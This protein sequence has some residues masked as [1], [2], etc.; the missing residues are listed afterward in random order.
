MLLIDNDIVKRVL[1]MR[2]LFR[3]IRGLRIGR[4]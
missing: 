3:I 2:G 1:T 4:R